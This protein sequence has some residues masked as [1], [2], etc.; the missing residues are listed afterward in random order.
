MTCT[1]PSGMACTPLGLNISPATNQI[2]TSGYTYDAAG[3][4]LSDN[5]HGY[6]YD[7]ENRITCVWGTDGTCTSASAMLYFYDPAGAA[8]GEAA[9]RHAGRLCL[10]PAGAYNLRARRERQLAAQRTLLARTAATWPPGPPTPT[11]R[12]GTRTPRA[13]LEPRRLA[14]H[15]A[16]ANDLQW[17][18]TVAETCTDTPYGMNLNCVTHRPADTSPMHFTGKQRDYESGLDYFGARYFGGGNTLGRFMTPD[19]LG[20]HTE[21]PQTMNKY[22]YVRNNPMSLT[23][24]TGLDFYLQCTSTDHTGCMQVQIDPNSTGK[25]WVQADKNGNAAIITS[26]SIRA[27]QNTAT[28]NGS[29]VQINGNSE[30]I[31]FD[32]P[33]SHTKDSNGNDVNNNPITLQGDASKG[34]GGFS[35]NVNG[36]CGGTCLSSGSFQFNGTPDQSRD[37]LTAAGAWDYGF[38]DALNSTEL[39][40]HP[41]T[42][43]FRFGSG[44]SLHVSVPWDF[45]GAFEMQL[46]PNPA[47]TVPATG[48]WHTDETLGFSHFVHANVPGAQ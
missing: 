27:G 15:R 39:G 46:V 21:D 38:W 9:S 26:D 32:N 18:L 44:P 14:G 23:D 31:Y 10:R 36:N 16:R 4:L 11:G 13:V 29:G 43:Q 41:E 12:T 42:D 20:G 22:A 2:T 19:P 37:A 3:N 5:T 33:A 47:S 34:L 35:F 17:D 48:G 28:V 1:A 8:G 30:G 40:H 24:P 6:V 7:A 45:L 25:T